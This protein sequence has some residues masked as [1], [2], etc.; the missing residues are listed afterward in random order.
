MTGEPPPSGDAAG[1][2]SAV[3]DL[4]V[5]HAD[6]DQVVELLREAAG[7]GRLTAAELDERV[8]AALTARTGSDLAALTGDLPA[9]PAG[10]SLQPKDLVTIDQ[11]FGTVER[12]GRWVVPRRMEIRLAAGNVKLDFTEAVIN[13]GSLRIDVDLGLGGDLLLVTKPGIVV[14]TDELNVRMGDIKVRHRTDPHE[15]VILRVELAGRIRGGD[16]KARHPRRTF[17]QW[18]RREHLS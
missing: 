10:S 1:R 4:R 7:D 14:V 18:I 17:G 16:I 8:E 11:R 3:P 12:T 15:P 2:P 13:T 5:S 9:P 6:R